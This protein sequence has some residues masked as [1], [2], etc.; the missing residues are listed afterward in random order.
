[1]IKYL[2][3]IFALFVFSHQS[4]ATE[5][6]VASGTVTVSGYSAFDSTNNII[7]GGIA[8]GTE[9]IVGDS[10]ST[11]N[12]CTQTTTGVKACNQTSVHPALNLVISFKL[13]KDLTSSAVAKMFIDNGSGSD[14][15]LDSITVPSATAGVTIV[16]LQTTW[17]A[18]CTNVGLSSDCS[19]TSSLFVTRNLKV[20]VDSDASGNVDDGEKQTM[21]LKLHYISPTDTTDP[22]SQS[23]CATTPAGAGMCNIE[24]YPGDDKA[25]I[26]SAIY[27][28]N[29]SASGSFPWES[30]AIFPLATASGNEA[31]TLTNFTTSLGD[32]IFVPF[33]ADDGT[34][35]DSAVTGGGIQNGQQYC[36]VYGTKNQAQN[37]YKFVTD[38]AAAPTACITPS[39]VVGILEDKSCFISTAAFGSDM[40]PE[41][42]TF[43]AFRNEF[44]LTNEPGRWFVRTYYRLSPPAA[45][46]IARNETLRA[47]IRGFL[48]PLLLFSFVALRFGMLFAL[49][50]YLLAAYLLYSFARNFKHFKN[51]KT[52]AVALILMFSPLL[53]ADVF[54]N[55]KVITREDAK[56]GLV[57]IT[58]DGTYIYDVTRPLKSESSRIS[59]GMASQPVI[60]ID[61]TLGNGTTNTYKFEDFYSSTSGAILSY[62]YEKYPWIGAGKLGYQIGGSLMVANGN[63]ILISTGQKSDERFTFVTA[64]INLGAVYRFEYKDKQMFAPY[65]AGGGTLLA[66]LEKRDDVASPKSAVGYGY[67]G[68]GGI[69]FNISIIDPD[70][71]FELDSEYGISN[72]WLSVE[73]RVTEVTND[74]FSFSN[75]YVNAGLS[76]DF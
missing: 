40:A 34:I 60:S 58:K 67:Y 15:E 56:E 54:E 71:S 27:A 10:N 19:G 43:R 42:K 17:G 49:I 51:K 72:L 48:Y 63:G 26:N 31:N 64:P 21:S 47:V 23:F 69:L 39:Q 18:I 41:V 62:D 32:P 74:A 9:P 5:I 45:H 52:L 36:F 66:L 2:I 13:T 53:K 3:L 1:M 35:P 46:F 76:F 68:L 70:V 59:F 65:V 11:V 75:Q 8:A 30:I 61:I 37:I 20:G 33:N 28:N 73:F 24:F 25:F 44:L 16:T 50:S 14:V 57:K 29:D 6:L 55:E 4:Q 7:F 12:T 38:A 22:V